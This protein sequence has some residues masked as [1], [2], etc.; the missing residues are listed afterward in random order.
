MLENVWK[1]VESSGN[2]KKTKKMKKKLLTIQKTCGNII[3]RSGERFE[4]ADDRPPKKRIAKRFFGI[5]AE[6]LQKSFK[7]GVDK[8]KAMC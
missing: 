5:G 2:T 6:K 3:K 8:K 1:A 7:K 4:R